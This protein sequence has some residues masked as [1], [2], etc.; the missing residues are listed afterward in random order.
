MI[1]RV[2][3]DAVGVRRLDD[4]VAAEQGD[5]AAVKSSGGVGV[6]ERRVE[7]QPSA[8]DAPNRPL[9]GLVLLAARWAARPG[10]GWLDIAS[11]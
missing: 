6:F 10:R 2:T 11:R 4:D 5:L 1:H 9:L 8:F 7:F 3:A